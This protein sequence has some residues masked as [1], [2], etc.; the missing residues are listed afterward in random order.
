MDLPLL[1]TDVI[2]IGL[3]DD[4]LAEGVRLLAG[5]GARVAAVDLGDLDDEP[6]GDDVV[7]IL[8]ADHGDGAPSV[9]LV[10]RVGGSKVRDLLH[11]GGHERVWREALRLVGHPRVLY[12]GRWHGFVDYGAGDGL[13]RLL[14]GHGGGEVIATEAVGD[15][16]HTLRWMSRWARGLGSQI[17]PAVL[18]ESEGGTPFRTHRLVFAGSPRPGAIAPMLC[19]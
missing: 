15:A 3:R 13:M 10:E 8:R 7:T 16:D 19:S 1:G 14:A 6:L 11:D 2:A 5:A 18:R 17:S 9:F 12:L 4:R